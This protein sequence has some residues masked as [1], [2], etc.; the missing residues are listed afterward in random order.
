M[1]NK[2]KK[3]LMFFL[4]FCFLPITLI[5]I[6]IRPIILIRFGNLEYKRIGHL[7]LDTA[8]YL[9]KQ[10]KLKR[11]IDFIGYSKKKASNLEL[12]NLWKKKI[13]IY[14]LSFL[15]EILI[16]SLNFFIKSK[17][18][19]IKLYSLEKDNYLIQN[20]NF[21]DIEFNE[22]VSKFFNHFKIPSSAKWVCI[23]NRDNAYMNNKFKFI[24]T[25]QKKNNDH[26]NFS[27]KDFNS[28][29]K[30]LINLGYYVI[31]VGS[32]QEEYMNVSSDKIIDYSHSDFKSD[33]MDLFLLSKCSFYLGSDSG[34]GNVS[35]ISDK[36]KGLCNATDFYNLQ[37]QN[38]KRVIIFKKYYS[39]KLNKYLS[40]K[41]IFD[42]NI[43]NFTTALE[44]EKQGIQLINNNEKEIE[45]LAKELDNILNN[46]Y[47]IDNM[48][49]ENHNKFWDIINKYGVNP[50][51]NY[52]QIRVSN[53]FLKNNLYLIE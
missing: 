39:N 50:N 27:L 24:P 7:A 53:Y 23:H 10:K 48:D 44:F 35:V 45:N 21:L 19:E 16:F 42:N 37:I 43:H 36:Y 34:L 41:E 49:A 13:K 29:S 46:D 6:L 11:T 15:F 17:N 5:I 1:I 28:A 2:Y 8:I 26:R 52:K 30:T 20:K 32:L 47:T 9:S 3:I 33:Y 38:F 22:E 40:L 18:H 51:N 25:N 12:V 31:R 14:N 4:L